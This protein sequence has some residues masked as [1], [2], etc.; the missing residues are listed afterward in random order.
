M[1]CVILHLDM[2][3]FF[4][5]IEERENPRFKEHPVVVGADPKGGNGRGV[6]STCNYEARKFGIHSAM[7]ISR[8]YRA[9]PHAIFLQ[10]N[11]KLY[12]AVSRSIMETLR[13]RFSIFEHVSIDEAYIDITEESKNDYSHAASIGKEIKKLILARERLTCSVGIGPNKLIAKI[14]ANRQK[15]DGLTIVMPSDVQ[16]FLDPLSVETLPGIGKKTKEALNKEGVYTAKQLRDRD[17]AYYVSRFGKWGY[18]MYAMSQGRDERP[19]AQSGEIKSLSR[20]HTFD[21]DSADPGILIPYLKTLCEKVAN[22][23]S[24][25]NVAFRTITLTV[26]DYSFKTVQK[27]KTLSHSA[28]SVGV[29]YRV[30]LQALLPFLDKKTKV[31]LLGVRVSNFS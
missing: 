20:N 1:N 17:E 23:A 31:R 5:A 30:T 19:V 25:K 7:P 12:G 10:G 8:A 21:T 13:A 28:K 11:G 22:D 27:S 26:R 9:C 24:S 6:V 15:P 2:D 4:A 29:I 14:A 16:I 3:Y 18:G